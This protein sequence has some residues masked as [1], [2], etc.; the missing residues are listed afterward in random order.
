MEDVR[1]SIWNDACN[2]ECIALGDDH[3]AFLEKA[4]E[5]TQKHAM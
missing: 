4:T 2:S 5:Y 3:A 1:D